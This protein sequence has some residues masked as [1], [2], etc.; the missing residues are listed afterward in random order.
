MNDDYEWM[1]ELL[2]AAV[3]ALGVWFFHVGQV[4]P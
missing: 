3:V 2:A 1:A 4:I